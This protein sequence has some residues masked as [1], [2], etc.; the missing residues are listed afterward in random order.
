MGFLFRCCFFAGLSACHSYY[1]SYKGMMNSQ[2]HL[3][4]ECCREIAINSLLHALPGWHLLVPATLLACRI[5][6]FLDTYKIDLR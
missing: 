5:V 1:Y 6:C 3:L 4:L 2:N